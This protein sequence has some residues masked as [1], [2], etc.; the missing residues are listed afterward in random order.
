MKTNLKHIG[1]DVSKSTLD[2]CIIDTAI[3]YYTIKNTEKSITSF[4]KKNLSEKN[5]CH[6]CMENTGKY[7]WLLMD[8]LSKTVVNF[9][10]INPVHLKKSL[11]LIRG[12][13]DK[14]DAF[15]IAG[16]IKKNYEE[17]KTYPFSYS[18]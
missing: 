8:I 11:G 9:Y 14:I 3:N 1:I 12:K 17:V 15:R 2:I 7:G 6:I 16:F 5:T 18:G 4:L 13:N 10:V